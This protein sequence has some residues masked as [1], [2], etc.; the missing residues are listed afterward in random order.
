MS[1]QSAIIEPDYQGLTVEIHISDVIS[2]KPKT[3]SFF[4][5][6]LLS[7]E[8]DGRLPFTGSNLIINTLLRYILEVLSES[9]IVEREMDHQLEW[10]A[11]RSSSRHRLCWES[12][13][14]V[15]E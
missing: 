10:W 12:S 3:F 7:F 11:C 5:K 14:E 2:K 8:Y 15:N 4:K 1:F 13:P 9:E 6:K